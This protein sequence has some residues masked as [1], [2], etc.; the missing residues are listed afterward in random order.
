MS[1]RQ[2]PKDSYYVYFARA[3]DMMKVGCS[4]RPVE[5]LPQIAEWI[6]FRIQLV[7]TMKGAFD[8]EA[9][10]H[11][12]LA[13][14]WSHLEWFHITPKVEQLVADVLAGKPLNLPRCDRG[15]GKE[16][17]K[18]LK[19]RATMRVTVAERRAGCTWHWPERN[20]H[21]PAYLREALESFDGP[22]AP[23]PTESALAAIARYEHELASRQ[24]A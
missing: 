4:R 13:D 17:H 7:A 15:A 20:N 6:P 19:K 22:H 8:L 10:I 16:L 18:T 5:R 2:Y 3:G 23:P 11:A 12:Y 1:Y 24:A 14:E 21:R 9:D